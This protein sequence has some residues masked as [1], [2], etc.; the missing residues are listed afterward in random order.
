[1][2]VPGAESGGP[3]KVDDGPACDERRLH[4]GV[5]QLGDALRE[6]RGQQHLLG[7]ADRRVGQLDLGAAQPLRRLQVLAVGALLD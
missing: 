6:H 2:A 5:G 3:G 7:R 4:R 1:M